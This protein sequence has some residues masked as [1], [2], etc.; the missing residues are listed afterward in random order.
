M[1]SPAAFVNAVVEC[2]P[3]PG[4]YSHRYAHRA[5]EGVGKILQEKGV[6]VVSMAVRIEKTFEVSEPIDPVLGLAERT[7][8]KL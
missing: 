2:S 3:A 1:G 8:E 6:E 5:V 4:S 7:R